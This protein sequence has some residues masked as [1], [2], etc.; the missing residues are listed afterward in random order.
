MAEPLITICIPAFECSA[1]IEDTIASIQKQTEPGLQILIALDKG[2][3]HSEAVLRP[4]AVRGELDLLLHE[5]NQ[6]WAANIQSMLDRVK[7]PYFAIH[8]HDDHLDPTYFAKLR[9]ALE[10]SPDIVCAYSDIARVRGG[11]IEQVR[12][13]DSITGGRWSRLKKSFAT[14]FPGTPLR[15]L[16]RSRVLS[17]GFRLIETPYESLGADF[18]WT[19][20][21]A[22]H[23][24]LHRVPEPLYRKQLHD[25]GV[26]GGWRAWPADKK[27]AAFGAFAAELLNRL[28]KKP[29]GKAVPARAAALAWVRSKAQAWVDRDASALDEAA[30]MLAVDAALISRLQSIEPDE[31][32][33]CDAMA[34]PLVRQFLENAMRRSRSKRA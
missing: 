22:L 21:L 4:Y 19:P 25:D 16:V 17:D 9:A 18:A 8:F 32:D 34:K 10:A 5:I 2:G 23:G 13:T 29:P 33:L 7:T 14:R 24:E 20:L 30:F 27:A 6:G 12:S 15:G 1:F 11:E 3:D 28:P 26:T 31:S